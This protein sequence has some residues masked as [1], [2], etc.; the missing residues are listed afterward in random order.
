MLGTW[1]NDLRHS[2]PTNGPRCGAKKTNRVRT[3]I[4]HLEVG[5]ISRTIWSYQNVAEVDPTI[6]MV[7]VKVLKTNGGQGRS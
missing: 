4:V 5:P 3:G 1:V 2:A 6:W 7:K